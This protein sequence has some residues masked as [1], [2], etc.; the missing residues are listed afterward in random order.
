MRSSAAEINTLNDFR[1]TKGYAIF[2]KK[3]GAVYSGYQDNAAPECSDGI[4]N[5]DDGA[6]DYPDDISCL[7]ALGTDESA[8]TISTAVA[9]SVLPD[10][11]AQ[12]I[13]AGSP[14]T[15]ANFTFDASQS[16]DDIK[17]TSLP[18][19]IEVAS[20][21]PTNLT[22]CQLWD[23]STAL[24]TASNKVDPT[25]AQ[26][27]PSNISIPFILDSGL[28]IPSQTSKTIGLA[29]NVAATTSGQLVRWG[30]NAAASQEAIGVDTGNTITNGSGITVNGSSGQLI[31]INTGG[32]YTVVDDSTPG[33]RI[34]SP[35]QSVEL[36]RLKFSATDE[37]INLRRVA[38]QLGSVATN[39]PLDLGDNPTMSLY[40]ASD[41]ATALA[42]A[43]FTNNEDYATSTVMNGSVFNVAS[44]AGRTMVVKGTIGA[45]TT[46]GPLTQ[47]GDLLIVT[48]DADA[49]GLNGGNYAV[50]ASSGTNISPTT[51]ADVT[52]TG[53]RIMK[54]Y[55]TM[56]KIAP[57]TSVLT[58]NSAFVLYRF[59][60]TANNGDVALYKFNFTIGSST[61]SATTSQYSLY[62]FIDS[63][64]SSADT[65]FSTDGLLNA[66]SCVN[67]KNVASQDV[68][69]DVIQVYMDATSC[70]T[71]T[72]TYKVPSTQTRWF[73]FRANV[74]SVETGTGSEYITAQLDGDAAYP[75]NVPG[76]AV[77]L[78]GLAMG[79]ASSI[80][81]D[82]HDDFIWSP[83]STTTSV[84][85]H[86]QD[87]TN[88]YGVVGLP[89]TSMSSETFTSTN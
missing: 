26:S 55:P 36:L 8:E 20:G 57:P 52:P 71:A 16:G 72:T 41:L 18:V 33:Y 73:E 50:G 32:S 80:D 69:D 81:G 58:T 47:S 62:A 39:T 79:S 56:A 43:E 60:V 21:T 23:G 14:F 64:F 13:I 28:V 3:T 65:T 4:D 68:N 27:A 74:A 76:G 48:W 2:I 82:S 89:S 24:N 19:D 59:S 86:D 42:T 9:I 25:V 61:K 5:D 49:A 17:F 12:A 31:T 22:G 40:D 85:R 7:S 37:A 70:N 78:T 75:T 35:G 44:G 88:G 29:C 15:F 66:G 6:T 54:A 63:G 11:A 34:V 38:F 53:V 51:A 77:V 87:W 84:S 67:G 45:I 10:P 83:I 46:V 30:I 1:E